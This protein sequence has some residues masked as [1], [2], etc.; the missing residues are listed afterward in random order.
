MGAGMGMGSEVCEVDRDLV[1]R[2]GD[3]G[4]VE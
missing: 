4:G 3:F 2:Q 1:E